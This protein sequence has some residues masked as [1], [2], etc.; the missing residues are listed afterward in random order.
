MTMTMTNASTNPDPVKNMADFRLLFMDQA[1]ICNPHGKLQLGAQPLTHVGRA[2]G[3]PANTR[4]RCVVPEHDGSY[5]IF[6]WQGTHNIKDSRWRIIRARTYDG[7]SFTDARCVYQS[8][9]DHWYGSADIARNGKTGQ[10]LCLQWGP[11]QMENAAKGGLAVWA[12]GSDDGEAWHPLS[13]RPVYH[14]HDAFSLTWDP[15]SQRFVT[16][17]ATYQRWADKPYKDNAGP[18]IRRVLHFR[19]SEDG[20]TW[21]PPEDVQ[22]LG[23]HIPEQRLITPD[24]DDPPELEFYRLCAFPYHD[25]YVGMMLNYLPD[26]DW[27]NP[28]DL[29][30]PHN[31]AEW[32]A[33]RAY[34]DWKRP[35][36]D[37]FAPGPADSNIHHAPI[38]ADGKHHWVIG[39]NV[40]SA[41]QW[42]LFHV[43]ALSNAAF[44]TAPFVHP[45]G[46]LQIEFADTFHDEPAR[47]FRGQHYLYAEL[48]DA[49]DKPIENYERHRCVL[50]A[51]RGGPAQLLWRQD[52]DQLISSRNHA[53]KMIRLRFYLRD[54]RIYNLSVRT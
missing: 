52:D 51:R 19:T 16:F 53:G 40:Y 24:A 13:D 17:Q 21:D 6:I 29:H 39:S 50:Y 46:R 5:T 1:D 36:R 42:Q 33:G 37:I 43:G 28:A 26:P 47:G 20:M 15:K 48:R 4:V 8:E 49:D 35:Y 2:L 27:T 3:V 31:G 14:D 10:Y 41:P 23:R 38:D 9:A 30:G 12:F 54:A 32:W 44:S 11:G 22:R 18:D 45:H 34:D 25:R 7:I